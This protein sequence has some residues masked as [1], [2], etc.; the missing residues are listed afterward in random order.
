[1][2]YEIIKSLHII[3]I[4][5]WMVGL[6]YLPRLFVYHCSAKIGSE[7]SEK[8]KIMERRLM[9]AIMEPARISSLVFGL[10]LLFSYSWEEI[11][12]LWMSIKLICVIGLFVIHDLFRKW[13]KNFETD[14]NIHRDKFFRILNE[15]PTLLMILIVIFVVVKPT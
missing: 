11:F 10:L 9:V 14:K 13:Q 3:S 12:T 2:N 7:F 8:L 15:V 1:M 4:I 5:S 6:L